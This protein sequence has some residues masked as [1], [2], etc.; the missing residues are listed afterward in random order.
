MREMKKLDLFYVD[1]TSNIPLKHSLSMALT[2]ENYRLDRWVA[3]L[4]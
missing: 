4:N 2:P 1:P 3:L